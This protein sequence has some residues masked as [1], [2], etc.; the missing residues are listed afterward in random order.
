MDPSC[1]EGERFDQTHALELICYFQAWTTGM[2]VLSDNSVGQLT[3]DAND[4][5]EVSLQWPNRTDSQM[6]PVA[7]LTVEDESSWMVAVQRVT[8]I[9]TSN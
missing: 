8:Y 2:Y 3:S 9:P 6:L 5:L 7:G 4:A 1:E